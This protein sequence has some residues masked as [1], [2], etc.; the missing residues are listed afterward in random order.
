MMQEQLSFLRT[1]FLRTRGN[2]GEG[3]G[4]EGGTLP[5]PARPAY[6]PQVLSDEGAVRVEAGVVHPG[7]ISAAPGVDSSAALEALHPVPCA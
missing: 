4:R 7:V 2:R 3:R 5:H 1:Q 6:L